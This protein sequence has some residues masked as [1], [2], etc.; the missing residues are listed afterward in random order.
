MLVR[1]TYVCSSIAL[2]NKILL[3]PP[4]CTFMFGQGKMEVESASRIPVGFWMTYDK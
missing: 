1:K 2:G 4:L 3:D